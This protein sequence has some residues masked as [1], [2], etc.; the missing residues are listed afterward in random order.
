MAQSNRTDIEKLGEFG[1]IDHLTKDIE[2]NKDFTIRGVGDDAAVLRNVSTTTVV[3]TDMLVEGIHFDLMYQPLKHLGY[4]SV[5]VNVSDIYAMNARPRQITVSVAISNRFSVE[6]LDELYEGIR[7]ACE[8]HEVDLVG[9]DTTSSLSG[10]VISITAIGQADVEKLVYRSGARPGDLLVTTG[11]LGAAY[12]GLQLLEREKTIFMENPEVQPDLENQDY[13]IGRILKPDARKDIF[14]E[15]ERAQLIPTSMIDISDG[16]AS[17]LF[18]ICDR[19]GVHGYILEDMI[20]IAQETR[21]MAFKFNI[22]P[23]TAALNG[24]EDYE[25]LFTIDPGDKAIVQKMAD[26]TIIG[27]IT[28]PG[29]GVLLYSKAGLRHPLEAQGWQHFGS[30]K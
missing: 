14:E 7:K 6:A 24:G 1:L 29:S 20:P 11:D 16:L 30:R 26:A 10:L 2:V 19:S 28:E 22:D 15:M 17:E 23:T 3:T 27:E 25:L 13:L 9:G 12:I 8:F 5:A 18:H 21:E 4:K